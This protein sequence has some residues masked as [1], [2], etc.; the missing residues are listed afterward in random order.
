MKKR[1]TEQLARLEAS[2]SVLH[3]QREQLKSRAREQRDSM[4]AMVHD[5]EQHVEADQAGGVMGFRQLKTL[6]HE[7]NRLEKVA[8]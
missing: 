3:E 1:L 2:R 4:P 5:V 7:R 6:H 8:D